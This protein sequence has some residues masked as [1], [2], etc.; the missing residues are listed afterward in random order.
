[1]LIKLVP[2]SVELKDYRDMTAEQRAN[3]KSKEAFHEMRGERFA[4][5]YRFEGSVDAN[6]GKRQGELFYKPKGY[7]SKEYMVY[8]GGFKKDKYHGHGTVFWPRKEG[9]TKE[10]V[11]EHYLEKAPGTRGDDTLPITKVQQIMNHPGHVDKM[12]YVG[13]F[14]AGL[15]HGRGTE[16]SEEGKIL[17]QGNFRHDRR[18]GFGT[19]NVVDEDGDCMYKGDFYNG[20]RHGFGFATLAKGHVY[21][22]GWKDGAMCGVGIYIHPNGDR[23]EGMFFENKPEGPGTHYEMGA[24]LD[25]LSAVH[26][27]Y[28]SGIP[29]K[30]LS[31][32]FEANPQDLPSISY[33]RKPPTYDSKLDE[34][35]AAAKAEQEALEEQRCMEALGWQATLMRY[36]RMSSEEAR[37]CGML[38]APE[39]KNII[40]DDEYS[41]GP[42]STQKVQV[43]T[44]LEMMLDKSQDTHQS[45]EE[46]EVKDAEDLGG[47]HFKNSP[48]LYACYSYGTS[49]AQI[50]ES[51]L[52]KA[53][54]DSN[55]KNADFENVF[56]CIMD[57]V[58][59]YN[60]KWE[61]ELQ[62]EMRERE[63]SKIRSSRSTNAIGSGGAGGAGSEID[64]MTDKASYGTMMS[65]REKKVRE[66]EQHRLE[67]AAR[68]KGGTISMEAQTR[69]ALDVI[70]VM[71]EELSYLLFKNHAAANKKA[72][73]RGPPPP[74]SSSR[75]KKANG[76]NRRR[77]HGMTANTIIE[78]EEKRRGST[79]G[80]TGAEV[81]ALVGIDQLIRESEEDVLDDEYSVG[82]SYQRNR[83]DD[84][85][86]ESDAD[87]DPSNDGSKA[88][89]EFAAEVLFLIRETESACTLERNTTHDLRRPVQDQW[90]EQILAT[91]ETDSGT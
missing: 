69:I 14:R 1:M 89:N 9:I 37:D 66:M 86:P 85:E 20:Q 46:Q 4:A 39:F 8:H 3:G 35:E 48:V 64:I 34:K 65:D 13:R 84:E 61:Q 18:D 71:V 36:V 10:N 53:T 75:Q 29:V 59:S 41:R 77:R 19:E 68:R 22:G 72:A 82:Y 24:D 76:G 81:K 55:A 17:Y 80:V 21:I 60:D 67:I 51:R 91:N 38:G 70:N 88:T 43:K 27:L 33:A 54:D 83:Y 49:A 40:V 58:E 79:M 78:R 62:R 11:T 90:W 31:G 74:S 25:T 6:G 42:Q 32:T 30:R 52:K 87:F 44:E 45:S 26:S 23:F 15:K 56:H 2:S 63:E 7:T 57:A 73:G 47:T 50:F 28:E 16:F 5:H 12:K